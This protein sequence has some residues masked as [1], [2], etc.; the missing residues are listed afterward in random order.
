M[1]G[2]SLANAVLKGFL[3]MRFYSL[4]PSPHKLI[5]HVQAVPPPPGYNV[6]SN[7]FVKAPCLYS[8]SMFPERDYPLIKQRVLRKSVN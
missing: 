2:R 5:Y 7:I 4:Y 3:T 1:D 6:H 8:K